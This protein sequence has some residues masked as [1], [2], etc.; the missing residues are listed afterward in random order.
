MVAEG[1]KYKEFAE[2]LS[3]QAKS[4]IPQDLPEEDQQYVYN[5]VHNFCF[6]AGEALANDTEH[7]YTVD[8]ASIITQFIGEWSFHKSLDVIRGNIP[9]QNRDS[10]MQKIAFT[11]FEIAKQ[12][13]FKNI[14]QDQMIG[15]VEHH[16]KK[17]YNEALEELTK[18]GIISAEVA[19][20]AA[21]QS[22]ID[23]MAEAD[24]EAL[25]QASDLKI[26]KLAAFALIAQKLP[27]DKVTTILT[28][29]APSEANMVMQ[30]MHLDDL[31]NKID[32][33]LLTQCLQ[34]FQKIMP[35]KETDSM[36]KIMRKFGRNVKSVPQDEISRIIQNERPLIEEIV[37]NPT[38][39][40][41]WHISSEVLD[42]ICGYIEEKIDD[43]KKK[44]VR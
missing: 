7:T 29:F 17:A 4:V 8:Q 10:I 18:R 23:A 27:Q 5:T 38:M 31:E 11:I 21:N 24:S 35:Q 26:L 44:S 15:L 30:Y 39:Y 16:V 22:N 32:K 36:P 6:M 2:D 41:R 14:P 43:Y 37:T 9:V 1:F 28:H 25:D 3:G 12:A 33:T 13:T 20:N 42:I 40:E 34:D 19:E